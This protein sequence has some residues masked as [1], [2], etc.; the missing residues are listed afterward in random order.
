MYQ[1]TKGKVYRRE[2]PDGEV[3]SRKEKMAQMTANKG[4]SL[5]KE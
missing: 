1:D 4:N 2:C 5:D 3:E